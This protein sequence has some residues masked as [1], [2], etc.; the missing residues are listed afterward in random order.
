MSVTLKFAVNG[1]KYR[2]KR[3]RNKSGSRAK[4]DVLEGEHYVPMVSQEKPVSEEV[5][6]LLDMDGDLFLNAVYVRQ[7]EIAD[8][9]EKR[10]LRKSR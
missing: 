6:K 5:K 2:I 10:L 9:I 4:L 7:G 3:Q 8:L 1:R